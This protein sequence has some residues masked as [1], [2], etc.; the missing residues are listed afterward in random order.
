MPPA[1]AV[2]FIFLFAGIEHSDAGS[3]G[4][5]MRESV[6]IN[7]GCD[8]IADARRKKSFAADKLWIDCEAVMQNETARLRFGVQAS[9]LRPRGFGIDEI[10]CGRVDTDPGV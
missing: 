10:P 7:Y 4:R 9:H 8:A 1:S 3:A 5:L 6:R 2:I